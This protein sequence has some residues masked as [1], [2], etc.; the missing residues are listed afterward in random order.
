MQLTEEQYTRIERTGKEF[1]GM[2]GRAAKREGDDLGREHANQVE[3]KYR[4]RAERAEQ[5][6]REANRWAWV[7]HYDQM[8]RS[9]LELALEARAKSRAL[10]A[11]IDS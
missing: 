10:Q 2:V 7:R 9:H 6:A 5:Q 11:G 3:H 1:D 4:T 8:R